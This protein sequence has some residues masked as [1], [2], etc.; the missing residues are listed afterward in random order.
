MIAVFPTT[1]P[2]LAR[3]AALAEVSE[4]GAREAMASAASGG[5]VPPGELVVWAWT[6]DSSYSQTLLLDHPRFGQLLPPGG[7]A[8]PGEDPRVAALRELQEETGLDGS[9]VDD[10]PA[11]VDVVRGVGSDGRPFQTFGMAFVVIAD[12]SSPLVCEPGQPATWVPTSSPP[13][14]VNLRH[15]R[16]LSAKC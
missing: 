8:E 13:A 10:H 11:L 9:L 1:S 6:F 5:R 3:L 15:W 7:R 2:L 14:R 12:P 4:D 16:R